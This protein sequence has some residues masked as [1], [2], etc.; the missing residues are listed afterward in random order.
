MA[1]RLNAL[2]WCASFGGFAAATA[3]AQAPPPSPASDQA[4][5]AA[6]GQADTPVPEAGFKI[7]F[8][9]DYF[10]HIGSRQNYPYS[11]TAFDEGETFM[12]ERLRPR[13]TV[14]SRHVGVVV[15]GQDTHSLGSRF[16]S[17]KAWLDVLNAYVDV[18]QMNGW[19]M[20]LGR[21]EADFD[22]LNRMVRTS[23]F[24]A[25]VRSM[26]IAEVS[27]RNERTELRAL[28]LAPLDNLPSQFNRH[29]PGERMWAGYARTTVAQ[30]TVQSY[31]MAK[32]NRGVRSETGA[33]GTAVVYAWEL[34][35]SGPTPVARLRW[36]AESVIERGHSS[37]DGV[38]AFGLFV[39]ADYALP[40]GNTVDARYHVTSGDA[41]QGDGT[42]GTYDT[43]YGSTSTYG[44]LGLFKGSNQRALSV[45]GL[46]KLASP[47]DLRWRYFNTFLSER[48][49][50]WYLSGTR[51]YSRPGAASS[52][53]GQ[54]ADFVFTYRLAPPRLSVRAAY[55]Q[56]FPG[57]HFE[58][59]ARAGAYEVRLQLLGRF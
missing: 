40:N 3:Y 1:F 19:G 7:A 6:A 38:S 53:V 52:H 34:L 51:N 56:F 26:D 31:L 55:L 33:L 46:L 4:D 16:G 47:L 21:I 2:L 14:S 49:D 57:A 43:F 30:H 37:T 35:G 13:F 27:W 10:V 39:Q 42:R 11:T 15:E 18:R 28:A 23:D 17:R 59:A 24:T 8:G 44:S 5:A 32:R 9:G 36:T 58:P 54:E 25:V 41:A 12:W 45:G 22:G 20:R 50:A 48:G 29:K